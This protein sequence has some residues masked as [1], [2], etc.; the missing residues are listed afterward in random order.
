[1]VGKREWAS[2][3]HSVEPVYTSLR[4]WLSTEC[5][6]IVDL[7]PYRPL[8]AFYPVREK[9]LKEKSTGRRVLIDCGAN[10]FY[11]S[12]KFLIDHY[13]VYLPFTHVFMI[14]PQA[15]FTTKIPSVYTNRYNITHY[16]IY[17]EI[18]TGS[19]QDIVKLLPTLVNQNDFVVLKFDVD[20]E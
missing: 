3:S 16:P 9:V 2:L 12:T 6:M 7:T 5:A 1:M 11:S 17:I 18:A 19:D 4:N 20:T 8:A 13:S 10:I 15:N 14:E